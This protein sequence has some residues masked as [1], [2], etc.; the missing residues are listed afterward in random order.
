[1]TSCSIRKRWKTYKKDN[2]EKLLSSRVYATTDLTNTEIGNALRTIDTWYPGAEEV[3]PIAVEPYGSVTNRGTAYRQPKEKADFYHL[4]DS[5][6]TKD[7]VPES[8]QQHYVIAA[9]IRGGV[10]GKASCGSAMNYYIDIRVLPDPEFST[11]TLMNAVYSKLHKALVSS[12]QNDIGVSFPDAAKSPGALLRLHSGK[13]ILESL[14]G[15]NWLKGLRDYVNETAITLVPDQA[16]F[17]R[18][19]RVQSKQSASRL[20]RAVKRNSLKED[21]ADLILANRLPLKRPYF[22]LQ[23]GSTGQHFPLFIGQS[24]PQKKAIEGIYSAYGLSQT[25]T[26]PWF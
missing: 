23:S 11:A 17:V 2:R 3:G 9:L 10:F 16:A 6:I 19:K 24:K 8:E 13:E 18:V 4:L 5:W 12:G 1:M 26:V 21:Q 7:Q 14:M 15:Q 20:R 25:A 22:R